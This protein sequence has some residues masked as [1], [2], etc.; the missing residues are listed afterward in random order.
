M[1]IEEAR[2]EATTA[3]VFKLAD[4]A[5]L[6]MSRMQQ[7]GVVSDKR[8]HTTRLKQRLLAHFPD[9]RA[10]SKGRDIM[11]VFDEDIGAALDRACEQDNDSDAVHLARAAKIVRRQIFESKPFTGSFGEDC[12]E[13]SVPH[14]LLALVSMVLEGPSIKHQIRECSTQAAL[15]IAQI[16]KFN[17]VKHMRKQPN[18]S[19]SIRHSSAQE[20]PLPIYIGLMLHAQTRKRDLV[21]WLF[22]LGLSVSYDRVLRLSAEMGNSVCQRFHME[23]VVCPP[24]LKGNVFTTAAVDNIDHNPSATTAKDSFHGTGISLLQHPTSADEGVHG[25]I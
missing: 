25:G 7:F 17:S 22:N 8:M 19:S 24:T 6:Y 4:M 2:L 21:D 10:Q 9:M 14:L 18:T 3:P 12:Q 23:Q 20:T 11:L 5:Q 16:L 15:S 13:R 1:Y